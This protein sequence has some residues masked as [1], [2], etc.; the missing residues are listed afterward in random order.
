LGVRGTAYVPA[1]LAPSLA[2]EGKMVQTIICMLL[3]IG[4]AFILTSISNQIDK[5]K[6]KNE[7]ARAAV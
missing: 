4:I 6:M 5:K 3:A 1:V 7:E 2:N